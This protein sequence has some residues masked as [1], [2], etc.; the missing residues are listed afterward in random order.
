MGSAIRQ[1]SSLPEYLSSDEL[2]TLLLN[3]ASEAAVERTEQHSSL[4]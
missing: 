1:S 2:E 4:L 3:R